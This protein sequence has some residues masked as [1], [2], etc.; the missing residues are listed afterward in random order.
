MENGLNPVAVPTF[1]K[2]ER[3]AHKKSEPKNDVHESLV[4]FRKGRRPETHRRSRTRRN[5]RE[6]KIQEKEDDGVMM[7]G[8]CQDDDDKE[9][10]ERK[11]VALQRIVPGGESLGVDK[12]FQETAGYI[13]ALQCQIKAMRVFVSFLQGMEKEK[14]SKFGG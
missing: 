8:S 5:I 6:M 11:I 13:L 3:K 7:S 4:S 2:K 14:I 9:E 1:H 10:V 12:L